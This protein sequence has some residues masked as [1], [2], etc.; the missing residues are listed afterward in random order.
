MQEIIWNQKPNILEKKWG[1][2]LTKPCFHPEHDF[3]SHVYIAP[4]QT[5]K[6]VCPGCGTVI[7]FTQHQTISL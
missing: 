6:H 2:G 1:S 5:Y 3:P 7:S 4:G